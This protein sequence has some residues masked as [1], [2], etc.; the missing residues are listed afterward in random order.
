MAVGEGDVGEATTADDDE[1]HA[2]KQRVTVRR[3]A[4]FFIGQ[5]YS[6]A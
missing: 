4:T 3:A 2:A 6:T 1:L 5:P